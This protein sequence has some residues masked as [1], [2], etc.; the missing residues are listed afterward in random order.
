M[1]NIIGVCSQSVPSGDNYKYVQT[2]IFRNCVYKAI[3]I[4]FIFD[5]YFK[6]TKIQRSA[7]FVADFYTKLL[8]HRWKS[9]LIPV[10]EGR[11][12]KSW[13]SQERGYDP[14]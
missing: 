3:K 5:A 2:Q 13:T 10:N 6:G 11:C 8:I 9:G 12:W 1:C 4:F 14:P 7:I